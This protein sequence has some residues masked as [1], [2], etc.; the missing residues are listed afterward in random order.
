MCVGVICLFWL[1]VL[2]FF[3]LFFLPCLLDIEFLEVSHVVHF[4]SIGRYWNNNSKNNI[5]TST[6]DVILVTVNG[7]ASKWYLRVVF[8]ILKVASYA[9]SLRVR[10][11]NELLFVSTRWAPISYKWGYTSYK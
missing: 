3:I 5:P 1:E 10:Y 7:C 11:K 9:G 6:F 2:M 4:T 8:D